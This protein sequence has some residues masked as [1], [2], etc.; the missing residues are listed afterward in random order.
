MRFVCLPKHTSHY[1]WWQSHHHHHLLCMPAF[2]CH[3]A[4]SAGWAGEGWPPKSPGE[5]DR[6]HS[7]GIDL[8]SH[9]GRTLL[10]LSLSLPLSLSLSRPPPRHTPPPSPSLTGEIGGMHEPVAIS[11]P[12][13]EPFS[14]LSFPT[15]TFFFSGLD[16]FW[17]PRMKKTMNERM[18]SLIFKNYSYFLLKGFDDFLLILEEV[19]TSVH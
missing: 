6:V 15:W 13:Q 11:K 3:R 1:I 10:C 9:N 18:K 2:K 12:K 4:G 16:P 8:L 14:S 19:S 5:A 17:F 7:T